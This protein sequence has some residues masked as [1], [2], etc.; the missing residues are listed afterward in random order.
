VGGQRITSTVSHSST[1]AAEALK[2]EIA[3]RVPASD[4]LSWRELAA[5]AG[6]LEV[7]AETEESRGHGGGAINYCAQIARVAV[8]TETGQVTILDFLTAHDVAEV[9]EP[10]SHAGQID[11]GIAMGVGFALSE[12]LAIEDGRVTAA[13]L[14]D[15][16]LPTMPDM[17]PLQVVLLPGGIGVGPLNVKSIAEMSNVASAAAIANAVSDAIGVCMD[18]L[19]LTPEKVLAAIRNP[20]LA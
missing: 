3:R 15:Y 16:K 7:T 6:P 12:D 8:D 19:P 11:G 13:H 1:T 10:V 20:G 9:I 18:T 2:A 14:G 5:K 4:G 17:P